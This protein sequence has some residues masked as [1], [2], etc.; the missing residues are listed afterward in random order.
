MGVEEVYE[1]FKAM[2]AGEEEEEIE[3]SMWPLKEDNSSLVV[4]LPLNNPKKIIFD[5]QHSQIHLQIQNPASTLTIK[6]NLTQ[7]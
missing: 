1:N 4:L 6:K 5:K 7:P 3:F 2:L